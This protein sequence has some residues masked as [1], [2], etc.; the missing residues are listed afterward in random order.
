MRILKEESGQ[1]LVLLAFAVPVLV[2][3]MGLAV[4]AGV[5]LRTQRNV[6]IAADAAAVAGALDYKYNTTSQP[7][8]A[9][10]AGRAAATQ[11][12]VTNG[13]HGAVVTI[14][15][16]P[17]SGPNAGSSGFV[18]AI[19]K[20]PTSTYFMRIFGFDNV[21]VSARA[22]VGAGTTTEGCV[23]ALDRSGD[24][25]SLTG[26]AQLT[27]LSCDIVDNSSS[28]NALTLTGSGS[29]TAKSIGIVGN[30]SRVGSGTLNPTPTTGLAPAADPLANLPAPTITSGTCSGGTYSNVGTTSVTLPANTYCTVSNV[31]SGSI[32]VPPG[33]YT[34]ISNTGS[35]HVTLQSGNYTISGSLSNTGSGSLTTS[36]GNYTIG[37]NLQCTGSCSTTLGSGMYEI[38]G[39][40]QLTG[41]GPLTG[42]SDT[43]YVGGSTTITGS[44]NVNL[45]A[46]T[47]G[48]YNGMLLFQKRGDS[49]AIAITGSSGSTIEGIVYAP[50]SPLTLTGSG[51]LS[52][53]LDIIADTITETGSGSIDVT[54]YANVANTDS[55]LGGSIMVMAE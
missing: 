54:N 2:G 55:V 18:E 21:N 37:G 17:L 52:V 3:F 7:T 15:I 34:S 5:L 16:P 32:T 47:S 50:S 29:I 43:F 49:S 14:N 30:Y 25:I 42:N 41:S 24:A 10:N 44:S 39:N 22:V 23:L 40:L 11:N 51:T 12:G 33:T 35:G 27:A 19:V 13:S 4:D 36:A 1:I 9:T 26:S 48:T 38:G 31:G 46:P 6:Q 53:S 45:T 8:S 20:D 28:S